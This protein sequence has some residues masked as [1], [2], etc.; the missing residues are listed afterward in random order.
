MNSTRIPA[1]RTNIKTVRAIQLALDAQFE[2]QVCR[3]SRE[4]AGVVVE[5]LPGHNERKLYI[6]AFVSGF[7]A[8]RGL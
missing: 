6:L 1:S 3:I 7:L 4:K 5:M 2:N 8:A